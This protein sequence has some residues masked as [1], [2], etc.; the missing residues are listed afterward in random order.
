[1][2]SGT[3]YEAAG[4]ALVE[5]PAVDSPIKCQ[6]CEGSGKKNSRSLTFESL[7]FSFEFA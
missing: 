2:I 3:C 7:L 1:M 6:T 5:T 4:P